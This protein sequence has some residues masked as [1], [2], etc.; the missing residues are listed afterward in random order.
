VSGAVSQGCRAG[1]F[2]GWR[3]TNA[4]DQ[5][6]RLLSLPGEALNESDETR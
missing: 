6:W 3:Y 5:L 1:W 2:V 4:A